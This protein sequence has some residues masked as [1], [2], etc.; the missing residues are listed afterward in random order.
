[1]SDAAEYAAVLGQGQ[2]VGI[3][4]DAAVVHG[5]LVEEVVADLVGGVG[6]HEHDFLEPR[7]MPA[8]RWQ[9]G[10][11]REW[12]RRRRLSAQFG[13]DVGGYVVHRG[14]VA[15]GAGDDALVTATMSL[16]CSSKPSDFIAASTA[17]AVSLTMSSPRV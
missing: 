7:A 9:S 4:V 17:S 15:V 13:A 5:I 12:E 11:G 2:D 6:E 8:G 14:V 16:S 3:G 1:M 10:C